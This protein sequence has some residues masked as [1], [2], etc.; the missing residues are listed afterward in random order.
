MCVG[1]ILLPKVIWM[2]YQMMYDMSNI[3][4]EFNWYY[5]LTGLIL[6]SICI[7]GATIYAS[8]KEL[9]ETPATLMRPKAPKKGKRVILEKIP[10]IWKH[11]SFTKKVT[12]RNLFRYKKR[13]LMTIIGILGCTSL[14]LVGFGLK[15]L[16]KYLITICKFL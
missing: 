7:I 2:M 6:I 10:F 4:L 16:K 14:I 8:Y 13:F 1:F 9:K 11:L 5:G 12:V 15:D 3:V